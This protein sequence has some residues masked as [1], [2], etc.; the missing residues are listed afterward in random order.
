MATVKLTSALGEHIRTHLNTM[1]NRAVNE[2]RSIPQPHL[3]WDDPRVLSAVFGADHVAAVRSLPTDFFHRRDSLPLEVYSSS[4]RVSTRVHAAALPNTKTPVGF[5]LPYNRQY[6]TIRVDEAAL[7]EWPELEGI[8]EI[9]D[10]RSE[11]DSRWA[12][13]QRSVFA[14][15]QSFPSINAA[16]KHTPAMAMYL[17][18]ETIRKMEEKVERKKGPVEVD[19]DVG[20][21]V[22]VATIH[23]M[24]A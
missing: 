17:P 19:V 22:A 16:I 13:T 12:D 21:L 7:G 10:A 20:S 24:V 11:F 18:S 3:Q 23:R 1:R 14:F 4:R 9:A 2:V 8:F 5:I 15:F 6:P